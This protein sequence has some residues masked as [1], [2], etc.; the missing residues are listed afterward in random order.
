MITNS[1]RHDVWDL[2]ATGKA[3][4]TGSHVFIEELCKRHFSLSAEIV[5]IMQGSQLTEEFFKANGFDFPIVVE[6][7]EGL[8]M[9]MP[10]DHLDLTTILSYIGEREID[11][12]DVNRQTDIR[13][14]ISDL[15][16]YYKSKVRE[17]VYNCISLEFSDTPLA[18]YVEAPRIVQTLDWVKTCW[19]D[20][21]MDDAFLKRPRVQKYC[22]IGAR[23]SF[24]DFHID[25]GGTSV[26]YHVLKGEK[27][28]Y[29]I[30][31]TPANLTLYHRWIT[32]TTQSETFFGDQVDKCYKCILKKGQTMLIPTG[33]IHAVFTPVD[34]LVF[35]GN[36]LHSFNMRMQLQ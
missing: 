36:F 14:H 1:H 17:R 31:P 28:F 25:F 18:E 2:N 8:Q 34:S 30:R 16:L 13:M 19:P 10:L 26:W 32:S 12:I 35:G 3:V 4:Q 29:L 33:W 27:V 6:R 22:L 5:I 11:V 15:L 7:P 23:N 20:D 24:T 21:P 9:K